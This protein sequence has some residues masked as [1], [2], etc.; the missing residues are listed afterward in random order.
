MFLDTSFDL[1]R[2]GLIG[3]DAVQLVFAQHLQRCAGV[4]FPLPEA[5]AGDGAR[6]FG[7]SSQTRNPR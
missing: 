4:E 6:H 1:G 2:V 3:I 5:L 7:S